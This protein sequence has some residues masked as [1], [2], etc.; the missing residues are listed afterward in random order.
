MCGVWCYQKYVAF[1]WISCLS[2]LSSGSLKRRA[3][4]FSCVISVSYSI[5]WAKGLFCLDNVRYT[6][7]EW[8]IHHLSLF[9]FSQSKEES[10]VPPPPRQP[11][12]GC[13]LAFS[14]Y[15]LDFN[16]C[17]LPLLSWAQ[18]RWVWVH[19]HSLNSVYTRGWD[20]LSLLFSMLG[21]PSFL[22]LSS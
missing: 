3:S 21:S 4:L 15:I 10:L 16:L 17:L 6:L 13:F 11:Q 9:L 12:A 20:S 19:L 2:L 8:I 1:S 22:S 18:L 5:I 7:W 14:W